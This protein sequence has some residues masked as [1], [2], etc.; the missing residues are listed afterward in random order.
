[1]ENKSKFDDLTIFRLPT[2]LLIEIFNYQPEMILKLSQVCKYFNL[3]ATTQIKNIEIN[4]GIEPDY[5]IEAIAKQL[6]KF[7]SI[8]ALKVTMAFDHNIAEKAELCAMNNNKITDLIL[9]DFSF[10]NPFFDNS[11][12]S[13]DNLKTLKIDNSDLSSSSVELQVFILKS[14]KNLKTL[15]ISGC[16]G[17]EIF[18]LNE[19]GR[20][21]HH[22]K[23][24]NLHLSPTYSYFDM[25]SYQTNQN[26]TIENLKVLSI[27]SKLVVMKKN[28]VR[29]MLG[30]PQKFPNLSKL[31]L[32]AELNFGG[33]IVP[34]I[35]QQFPSLRYISLGKGVSTIHNH[36]FPTICNNYS[37]LN[38]L[39]FHFN[40]QDETLD[41]KPLRNNTALNQLTIGLTKNI[42][43]DNLQTI[44][45]CFSNLKKIS[46]ILYY[47]IPSNEKYLK[48][49]IKIFPHVIELNLQRIGITENIKII[50]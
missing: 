20:N 41:L 44:S 23:I 38:S 37:N 34:V 19:I 5:E 6:E 45:N 36:D 14:C 42:T 11:D 50:L 12:I 29:N 3:I 25:S 33:D 27:K 26:W 13:F 47:L 24:E 10:L 46:I 8:R 2:E 9:S 30:N 22:T 4:V 21:L 49:L 48:D 7:N 17:L 43:L 1:M 40:N 15:T 32:I 18:S 28:F 31:E 35:I 16:C 39:E